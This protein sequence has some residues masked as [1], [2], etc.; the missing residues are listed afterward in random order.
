MKKKIFIFLIV[1]AVLIL[2][3]VSS[4]EIQMPSEISQGQTVIAKVEGN[5]LDPILKENIE[6]YRED[7]RTS[8][9]YDVGKINGVYHIFFQ[10]LGKNENNYSIRV[11]DVRYYVGSQ[12]SNE[13]FSKNFSVSSESA[14]FY[15]NK[16][17]VIADDNFSITVQN[18]NPN[19]I[20]ITINTEVSSGSSEGFFDFLFKNNPVQQNSINLLSGETEDIDVIIENISETTTRL[21]TLTSGNTKY[22]IPAYVIGQ[23]P[24]ETENLNE[25]SSNNTKDNETFYEEKNESS[26]NNGG[27]F[28]DFFKKENKT[29]EDESKENKSSEDYNIVTDD[30]GNE[31]AVDSEGNVI[32][33]PASSRTCSELSGAVCSSNQICQDENTTYAKDAKCCLSSCVKKPASKNSKIIGWALIGLIV[34]LLIWF[35]IK[36][37]KTRSRR[38]FFPK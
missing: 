20:A 7:I 16:G 10:T 11:K 35:R 23:I 13:A 1:F 5:F 34:I 37:R 9:N 19:S 17:F 22:E 14:D 6:F 31:Y 21:I 36:F 18:L 26:D 12:I 27:S 4:I 29:V 28:W 15:I 8:F 32:D 38:F 24:S 2:P 33:V 25:S 30:E 3:L